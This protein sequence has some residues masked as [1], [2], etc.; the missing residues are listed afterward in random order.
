MNQSLIQII[1]NTPM[2]ELSR[3]ASN[4]KIKIFAKLEGNNPGGSI[5]DRVALYMIND[6]L[7]KGHIDS[8]K[9]VIEATSGNTGIGLAMILATIQTPFIAVMSASVSLERQK[10]L[11]AYGAKIILTD[12]NKGTNLAIEI[13]R[14]IVLEN[15]KTYLNLDQ[16]SNPG[17]VMAHYQTTGL[18]IITQVPNITHFVTGMGTGGTLMGVGKRLK[19]YKATIQIIGV[20]PKPHSLIQ[21]LRNMTD[22]TPPI[23]KQHKLD[24][25]I[26]IEDDDAFEL[27]RDIQKNEGISVGISSG[28]NLWGAMQIAREIKSGIIVTVFP[29]R[30]ERY[31]ST[32]LFQ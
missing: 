1:G 32:N 3:Y 6:A 14:Q 26:T 29:D 10:M 17:N 12:G 22:Y 28:A 5:K 7:Q 21:G 18:E 16:F 9:T 23:F 8:K 24:N 11:K 31:L 13:V 2:V 19:Q 25:T 4:K 30:G 20:E 27:A 15:P